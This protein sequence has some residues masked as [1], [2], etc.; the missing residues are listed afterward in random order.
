MHSAQKRLAWCLS[1][2]AISY[3]DDCVA[4]SSVLFQV[5]AI[6]M[7]NIRKSVDSPLHPTCPRPI[8]EPSKDD[9][10][11]V[12]ITNIDHT[13]LQLALTIGRS[14]QTGA[15]LQKLG[16]RA[17]YDRAVILRICAVRPSRFGCALAQQLKLTYLKS[18]RYALLHR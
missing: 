12:L 1:R 6:P 11:I 10:S 16:H 7:L 5:N 17:R 2:A 14:S 4:Q 15:V 18:N 3:L 13:M 9:R 8:T